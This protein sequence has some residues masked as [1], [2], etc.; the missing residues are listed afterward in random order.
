[1]FFAR[2]IAEGNENFIRGKVYV[3]KPEN[4]Y[5]DI[6]F[7]GTLEI[8]NE[9]GEVSRVKDLGD[10]DV[11]Y[12]DWEFL[13]EVYV[14]VKIDT[15]DFVRGEIAVATDVEQDG[16]SILYTVDHRIQI[17][18]KGLTLLDKTNIHVGMR[19]REETNRVWKEVLE[20]DEALWVRTEEG[21]KR[22]LDEFRLSI[23]GSGEI[24]DRYS[25]TC[26]SDIGVELTVGKTYVVESEGFTD[27][28]G[29]EM[30]YLLD[31]NGVLNG[32][33]RE[34]FI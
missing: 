15:D 24:Q 3:A 13:E 17:E 8:K 25:L 6:V 29:Q 20:V 23:S 18:E 11:P 28:E 31:D 14:V 9:L 10:S 27:G 4:E 1:M 21:P 12:P 22:A 26:V 32:Y 2:Y 33:F 19:I 16:D 7:F 5:S 34:R 30:V